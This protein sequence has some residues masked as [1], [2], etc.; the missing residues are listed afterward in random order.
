L[1]SCHRCSPRSR[2]SLYN[3]CHKNGNGNHVNVRP[4]ACIPRARRKYSYAYEPGQYFGDTRA[5]GSS[6]GSEIPFNVPSTWRGF[7]IAART[8]RT[9]V[10]HVGGTRKKSAPISGT[11][12]NEQCPSR[13]FDEWYPLGS[14]PVTRGNRPVVASRESPHVCN[15]LTASWSS[16][17][18]SNCKTTHIVEEGISAHRPK[19]YDLLDLPQLLAAF[20]GLV[21]CEL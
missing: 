9:Y 17:T 21:F 7:T 13:E 8:T 12:G 19:L 15:A 10:E 3:R 1:T 6:L 20:S 4:Q 18:I 2:V 16:W 11:G 14:G 5:S